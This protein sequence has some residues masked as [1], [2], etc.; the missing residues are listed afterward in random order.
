[1]QLYAYETLIRAEKLN[2]TGLSTVPSN[3]DLF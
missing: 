3:L 2:M 1:M